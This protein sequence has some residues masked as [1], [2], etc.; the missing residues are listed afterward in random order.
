MEVRDDR[1]D[2]ERLE[3][4]LNACHAMIRELEHSAV[5]DDALG[6]ALRETCR[7]IEARLRRLVDAA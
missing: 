2:V 6:D 1:S 5:R 4:L 3:S 7:R